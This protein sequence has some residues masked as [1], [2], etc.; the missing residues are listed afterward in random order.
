MTPLKKVVVQCF[1]DGGDRAYS[2]T[3]KFKKGVQIPTDKTEAKKYIEARLKKWTA[4]TGIVTTE[5]AGEFDSPVGF[6]FDTR[7]LA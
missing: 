5:H 6:M 4:H 2:M 3:L 1:T 7:K